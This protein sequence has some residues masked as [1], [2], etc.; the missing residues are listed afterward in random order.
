MVGN[1]ALHNQL[2]EDLNSYIGF[3]GLC[4]LEFVALEKNESQLNNRSEHLHKRFNM[5]LIYWR[6]SRYVETTKNCLH[7]L[8]S[9]Q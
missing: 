6:K 1:T 3:H 9:F 4:S 5:K 7:I 2:C 8:S